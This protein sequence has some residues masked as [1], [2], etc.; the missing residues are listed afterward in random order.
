MTREMMGVPAGERGLSGAGAVSIGALIGP[1]QVAGR[2]VEYALARR[3]SVLRS[4]YVALALLP[5]GMLILLFGQANLWL[6]GI[7]PILYLQATV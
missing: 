3:V 6:L 5:L 7:A 2:V 1:M 4:A